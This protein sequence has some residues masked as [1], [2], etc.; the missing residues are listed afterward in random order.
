MLVFAAHLDM[1][2]ASSCNL[3]VL[4]LT[5]GAKLHSAAPMSHLILAL[6]HLFLVP[7]QVL[8]S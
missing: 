6:S 2:V 3:N 4:P 1:P 5:S 7:H 8:L